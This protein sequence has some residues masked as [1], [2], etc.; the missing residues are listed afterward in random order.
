VIRV[1]AWPHIPKRP[2]LGGHG[3][4]PD[5]VKSQLLRR[6]LA[7]VLAPELARIPDALVVPLGDKVSEAM[8]LLESEGHLSSA[9]CLIGFPHPSGNNG[10]RMEKWA[11]NRR[12][13]KLRT[14]AWFRG[15]PHEIG[16]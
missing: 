7:D 6:Y 10:R 12:G 13:L 16:A 2:H 14:R 9:R 11:A 1:T 8:L 3:R 15:H 4:S 5:L